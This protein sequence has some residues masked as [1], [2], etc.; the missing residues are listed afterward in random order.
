MSEMGTQNKLIVN[1]NYY[2]LHL[3]LNIQL[4]AKIG[5]TEKIKKERVSER[6]EKLYTHIPV[7]FYF[8]IFL[9]SAVCCCCS[10]EK[11]IAVVE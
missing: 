8:I 11:F 9:S 4:T 3:T 5:C 1:K 2:L 7:V 6:R 10:L